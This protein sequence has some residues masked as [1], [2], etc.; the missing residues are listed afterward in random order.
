MF[1]Q[2]PPSST[3]ERPCQNIYRYEPLNKKVLSSELY[4]RFCY[5]RQHHKT[6]LPAKLKILRTAK[7]RLIEQAKKRARIKRATLKLMKMPKIQKKLLYQQ[8]S[9][10]LMNDIAQ[11]RKNYSKE[12]QSWKDA[13]QNQTWADWLQQKAE[14]GDKDALTAMRYRN[15]KN[16][17]NYSFWS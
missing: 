6:L 2:I 4:S 10:S 9:N 17:S 15:R 13:Y 5:E 8:I 3:A 7:S 14:K 11:I 16:S 12:H 1:G